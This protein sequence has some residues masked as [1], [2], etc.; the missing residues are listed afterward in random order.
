MG[1]VPDGRE[2]FVS[3]DMQQQIFGKIGATGGNALGVL[4]VNGTDHGSWDSRF[5]GN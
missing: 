4:L 1:Y 3:P 5:K 2:C